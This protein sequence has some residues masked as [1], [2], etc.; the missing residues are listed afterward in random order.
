M[1][2]RRYLEAVVGAGV[3]T[4]LAGCT[5]GGG[6]D[7]DPA[8]GEATPT[9]AVD[10]AGDGNE[11][12]TGDPTPTGTIP[13]VPVADSMAG[14]ERRDDDEAGGDADDPPS[15]AFDPE[16]DRLFVRGVVV[17]GSSSCREASVETVEYED[18]ELYVYV[19][20]DWKE[21]VRDDTP[22]ECTDD[23]STDAYEVE[24]T[25]DDGLPARVVAEERDYH[26]EERRTVRE[27]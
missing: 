9:D 6:G 18:G 17:V 11:T 1:D 13:D 16:N 14:W 2:R 5:D 8:A 21:S 27:R 20:H 26:A 23:I 24:V 3:G 10:P 7:P 25:F 19:L 15:V 22:R 4:F 12:A